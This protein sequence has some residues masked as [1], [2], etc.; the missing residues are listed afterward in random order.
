MPSDSD[1]APEDR[2][3]SPTPPR[4]SL[5]GRT[6]AALVLL[7]VALAGGLA[8]V[9]FDRSV[10][11]PRAFGHPPFWHG[12]PHGR[13]PFGEERGFR[14]RFAAAIGLTAEQQVR[15]DS[16]MGRQIRTLR[17]IREQVRPRI[18]SVLTETR[19]QIDSVLT[20]EQRRKAE[21]L[22][23]EDSVR[24][25]RRGPWMGPPAGPGDMGPPDGPHDRE[26]PDR[27]PPR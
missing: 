5:G 3:S 18:D 11:L 19:R 6:L 27:E 12:P 9:A 16:I 15:I 20:P 26:P 4:S 8:G 17:G 14:D 7:L 25:E 13:R 10:L 23:R 21:A 22:R 1:A 2:M 24:R